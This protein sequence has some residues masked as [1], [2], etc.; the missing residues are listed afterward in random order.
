MIRLERYL[1]NSVKIQN[2][3]ISKY[4]I[5]S[6]FSCIKVLL[7]LLKTYFILFILMNIKGWMIRSSSYSYK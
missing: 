3:V 4:V 5:K 2:C 6:I 1:K 7:D